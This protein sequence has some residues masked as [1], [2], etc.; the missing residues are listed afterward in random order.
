MYSKTLANLAK[1]RSDKI[2]EYVYDPDGHWLYLQKGWRNDPADF[3]HCVHDT[4]V[5]ETLKSFS[6]VVPCDCPQCI[7]IKE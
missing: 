5:T 7:E 2:E 1:K 4:T 3:C 6:R